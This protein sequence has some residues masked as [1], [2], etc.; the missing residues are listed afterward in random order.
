MWTGNEQTAERSS[1][2]YRYRWFADNEARETSPV[3]AALTA[4]ISDDPEVLALIER[5]PEPKRQPN[6]LLGAVRLHGGPID[7][8]SRFRAWLLH[9]WDQVEGTMRSRSTQTNEPGRCALLLP[10]LCSLPQPLALIEVGASSGLCLNPDRY[11]YLYDD[12]PPIGP[13]TARVDLEC[14][15][16]GPVPF[17]EGVPHVAWRAGIDLNPL[18]PADPEDVRWLESL[19]WPGH[20]S[21]HQRLRGA[22]ETARRH[23]VRVVR[24]DMVE[25]LDDLLAEVP[26]GTTPVVF[27]SAVLPYLP[28][29]ERREF[30]EAVQ[31][32][33]CHWISNEAPGAL[34]YALPASAGHRSREFVLRMDGHLMAMTAPHGQYLR[35]LP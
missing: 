15:T 33:S 9:H 12:R 11:R 23:P 8:H 22:L 3:Y 26:A 1:T 18:D 24:G 21:R 6:L 17:P 30:V 20:H 5:L 32:R 4:S 25:K 29:A 34:P 28:E 16:S 13:S 7:D 14:E 19:I 2:A 31:E 10:L 27:H 35:W